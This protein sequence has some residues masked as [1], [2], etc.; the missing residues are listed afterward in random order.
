MCYNQSEMLNGMK[1]AAFLLSELILSEAV[2]FS[3]RLN[4]NVMNVSLG[5]KWTIWVEG[6]NL[7]I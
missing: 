7:A 5:A 2:I 4:I 1:K 6:G 3:Q